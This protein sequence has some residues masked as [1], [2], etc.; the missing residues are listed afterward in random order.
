M[1]TTMDR[2]EEKNKLLELHRSGQISDDEFDEQYTALLM[3]RS[4]DTEVINCIDCHVVM[5][6]YVI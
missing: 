2:K 3:E 4:V 6:M 5:L 1:S